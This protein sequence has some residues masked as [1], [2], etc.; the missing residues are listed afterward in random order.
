MFATPDR[1]FIFDENL[2]D[3]AVI[4]LRDRLFRLSIS[5]NQRQLEATNNTIF[6]RVEID[7]VLNVVFGTNRQYLQRYVERMLQKFDGLLFHL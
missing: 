2:V 7:V 4:R 1:E 6:I 5:V 3:G